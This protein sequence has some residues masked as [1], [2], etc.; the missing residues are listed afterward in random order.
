MCHR[1][2]QCDKGYI[3]NMKRMLW[4]SITLYS[5]YISMD[6]FLILVV[7]NLATQSGAKSPAATSAPGSLLEIAEFSGPTPYLI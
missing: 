1:Y 4:D 5:F 2:G 3:R 7:Y 6:S